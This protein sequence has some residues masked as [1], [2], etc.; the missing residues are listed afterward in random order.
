M[1]FSPAEWQFYMNTHTFKACVGYCTHIGPSLG[2]HSTCYNKVHTHSKKLWHRYKL[3]SEALQDFEPSISQDK[4]RMEWYKECV[5]DDVAL[6][7][8]RL[9]Q[10]L[11]D[12]I[13][14]YVAYDQEHMI[15]ASMARWNKAV[16]ECKNEDFGD[17]AGW[18]GLM[19]TYTMYEGVRYLESI[20]NRKDKNSTRQVAIK[21]T[22]GPV[23]TVYVSHD[24][25]GVRDVATCNGKGKQP[26]VEEEPG[27]WWQTIPIEPGSCN[28]L[29]KRD[30]SA[31]L[32]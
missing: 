7:C 3:V 4:R 6:A 32:C 18:K 28:L 2:F 24:H 12:I 30:V 31:P 1:T 15:G 14:E 17:V 19:V 22:S 21:P 13:S 10:E 26:I 20:S 25:L 8:G 9:P 11:R 27:V 5:D 29:W 23:D 16:E